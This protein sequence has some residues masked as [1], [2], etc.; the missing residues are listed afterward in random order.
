MP[1]AKNE[2]GKIPVNYNLLIF[3]LAIKIIYH[4]LKTLEK[5]MCAIEEKRA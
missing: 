4:E 3:Q 5:R 2:E 1:L